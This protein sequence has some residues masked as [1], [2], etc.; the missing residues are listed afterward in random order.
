N[1]GEVA[2][3]RVALNPAVFDISNDAWNHAQLTITSVAGGADVTLVLSAST[4]GNS[5]VT[6]FSNF[7]VA[8]LNPYESRAEFG[9]R[10]GGA[11]EDALFDN[12]NVDFGG[13]AAAP[14][15]TTLA[16]M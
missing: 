4:G 2:G 16:L 1:N 11:T 14:E 6:P 12:I 15:P 5:T 10:T 9:G 7:F 3:S 13:A 8:G